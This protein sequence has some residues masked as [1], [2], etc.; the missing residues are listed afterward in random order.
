VD[1]GRFHFGGGR[2][3]ADTMKQIVRETDTAETLLN[4]HAGYY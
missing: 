3:F 1:A 4:H 2:D